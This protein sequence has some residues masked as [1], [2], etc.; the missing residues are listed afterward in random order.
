MVDSHAL[1]SRSADVQQDWDIF[2]GI[3]L[4]NA[5]RVHLRKPQVSETSGTQIRVIAGVQKLAAK[6]R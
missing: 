4:L 5:R 3:H 2:D 1:C 6:I